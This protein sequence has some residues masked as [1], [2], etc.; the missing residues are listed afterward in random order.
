MWFY[1]VT[2]GVAPV[3]S[4]GVGD[5]FLLLLGCCWA[6]VSDAAYPSE[7]AEMSSVLPWVSCAARVMFANPDVA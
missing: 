4:P 2:G 6:W 1:P 7:M 5:E 3:V